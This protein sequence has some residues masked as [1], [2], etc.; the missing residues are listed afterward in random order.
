[1]TVKT[2]L[3]LTLHSNLLALGIV[4]SFQI[5]TSPYKKIHSSRNNYNNRLQSLQELKS[6]NEEEPE[7]L[8]L[9]S[10]ISDSLVELG[11]EAG[12]LAAAR[13]RNE[14]AKA[15]LME[16]VRKEEEEADLEEMPWSE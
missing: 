10:K 8:I 11:S 6:S 15:Q 9:G 5:A 1:M 2:I 4:S 3:L 16:Q 14:E 12:Y 13:K 7:E